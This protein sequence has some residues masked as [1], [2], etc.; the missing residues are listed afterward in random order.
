MRQRAELLA[1]VQQTNSQDH[2]PAMGKTIASK[3]NREGLAERLAAAAVQKTIA[4]A[5]AL[6]TYD[7]ERRRDLALSSLTTAK[8]HDANPLSLWQTVPGIGNILSLV[9]LDEIHDMDR[10]PRGQD[11]ASSCRLVKGAQESAGKPLG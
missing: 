9:L 1:H 11:F 5:L 4:A 7:A 10:F 8:H 2:W 3:A 6:L